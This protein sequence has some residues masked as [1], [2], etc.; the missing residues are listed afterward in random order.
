LLYYQQAT[1]S[2]PERVI[3]QYARRYFVGYGALQ[4][5]SD[6]PPITEAQAEALDTLHFLGDKF[7]ISTDFQKGD[8]QYINNTAIFHAR[9]A[10]VDSADKQ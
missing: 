10:F 4:R 7:S 9:D 6:I 2:T 8:I 1:D 5:S 3:L